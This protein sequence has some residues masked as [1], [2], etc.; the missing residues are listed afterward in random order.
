MLDD[1]K[2]SYRKILSKFRVEYITQGFVVYFLLRN[3]TTTF[4]LGFRKNSAYSV[5]GKR[6]ILPVTELCVDF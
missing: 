6:K 5:D 3:F 4:L 1:D 2:I